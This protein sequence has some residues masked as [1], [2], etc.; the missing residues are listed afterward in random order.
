MNMKYTIYNSLFR[1]HIKFNILCWGRSQYKDIHKI[2][3]LQKRAVRYIANLKYNS[4]TGNYFKKLNILKIND[5]VNLNTANFMH[6]YV[7]NK[8]PSSFDNF[9]DKQNTFNRSLSFELPKIYKK[10]HK[11]L[12]SFAL[13]KN[14]NDISLDLTR[15]KSLKSF[16]SIKFQ[17]GQGNIELLGVRR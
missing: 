15:K 2:I 3:T 9:F 14:W 8:I 16:Q 12:P 11:L 1:S 5:L 6:R 13:I 7:D 10:E 4:H 17:Q